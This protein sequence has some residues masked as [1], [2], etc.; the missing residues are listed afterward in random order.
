MK[1]Y[2]WK[3]R[4]CREMGVHPARITYTTDVEHDGRVYPVV[5]DA[6]DVLRCDR[7]GAI[8][9]DDQANRAVSATFRKVAGLLAPEEIR[10]RREALGLT[11]KELAAFLDV[12]EATV[13]RWETGGQI[14]QRAM[15]RLLR[16]FFDVPE[17]R[18][19]LGWRPRSKELAAS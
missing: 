13:S 6:L 3:C 1:P 12:A 19:Y 2:P 18:A 11:Q 5:I 4:T 16:L 14:Q 17:C 15:D 8:V 9:L 10:R 7:C